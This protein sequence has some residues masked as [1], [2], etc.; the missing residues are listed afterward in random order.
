MAHHNGTSWINEGNS[1][2]TIVGGSVLNGGTVTS[3]TLVGSFSPFTI[4][5]T[6]SAANPLP[7]IFGDTKAFE[8]GTGVQI[9][10]TNLTEKDVVSYSVERSINGR[11][12]ISI[13]QLGARSNVSDAQS[14]LSF[15]GAPSSTNFYRIKVVEADG[16]IVYSKLM[17][18][19]IGKSSKGL[20]LYPNP[21]VGNDLS[22]GFTAA[23]GQYNLSV[24]NAAGQQIYSQKINHA[25]GTVSQAITLPSTVKAG[26]YNMMISGDN[27][28][29]TKMFF[30]Q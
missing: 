28:K 2:T 25:G 11:D 26:V 27:Y 19:D 13:S 24:V 15:D 4:G 10:W 3:N 14:Y 30:I 18:V 23:R 9:E 8:K 16:H 22:I 5:T 1:G 21:V 20:V 17:K 7:V 12:F 6:N 29:E